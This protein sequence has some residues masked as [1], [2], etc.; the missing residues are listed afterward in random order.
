MDDVGLYLDTQKSVSSGKE[1]S[2]EIFVISYLYI[3][4]GEKN[5]G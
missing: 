5:R 2:D 4:I 1:I 3:R